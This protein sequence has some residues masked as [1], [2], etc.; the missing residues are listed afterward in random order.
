VE[1]MEE[2]KSAECRIDSTIECLEPLTFLP[3]TIEQN[4]VVDSKGKRRCKDI[5]KS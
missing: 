1:Y 5:I 3:I 4:T 2:F